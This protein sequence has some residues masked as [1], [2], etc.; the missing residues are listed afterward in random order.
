MQFTQISLAS[1]VFFLGTMTVVKGVALAVP[2]SD[3]PTSP[4]PKPPAGPDP[5]FVW[6]PPEFPEDKPEDGYCK[7]TE[8]DVN[9]AYET[10]LT[11]EVCINSGFNY[12]LEG[13]CWNNAGSYIDFDLFT[14][15]CQAYARMGWTEPTQLGKYHRWYDRKHYAS[16]GVSAF[17]F[18]Y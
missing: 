8:C 10:W 1:A 16:E 17:C 15:N 9:G 18:H 6:T 2:D 7:Y 11:Q 3:Q 5:N 4:Q 12:Q 13:H 14:R